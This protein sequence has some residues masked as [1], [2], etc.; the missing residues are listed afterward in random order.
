MEKIL[1]WVDHVKEFLTSWELEELAD[2]LEECDRWELQAA[3][4]DAAI[5]K[6]P[7][8]LERWEKKGDK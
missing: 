2:L 5:E 3:V 6:D 4:L 7:T 8:V 1:T